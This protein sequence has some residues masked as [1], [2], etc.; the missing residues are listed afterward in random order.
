[1]PRIKD[2]KNTNTYHYLVKYKDENDEFK[3][4]QEYFF[5]RNEIKTKFG[6]S[7]NLIHKFINDAN[8]KS[9]K[10]K[11]MKIERVNV[12]VVSYTPIDKIKVIES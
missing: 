6:M 5:T 7:D 11:Y 8:Y 1:M 4:K 9:I 2:S 12:P 3:D 10:F